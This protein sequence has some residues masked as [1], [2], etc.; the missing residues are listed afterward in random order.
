[1]AERQ[2]LEVLPPALHLPAVR[3]HREILPLPAVHQALEV[4]PP[5]AVRQRQE[6]LPPLAALAVLLTVI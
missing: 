4:L 3:Q 6:V 2:A 1:M 5:P